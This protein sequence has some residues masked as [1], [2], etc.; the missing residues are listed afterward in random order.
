MSRR[1]PASDQASAKPDLTTTK[2]QIRAD[3]VLSR[4]QA[5]EDPE[6]EKTKQD[7]DPQ[8]SRKRAKQ[9]L[10][11]LVDLTKRVSELT[12]HKGELEL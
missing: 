10:S 12:R 4:D 11:V 1:V 2:G 5:Q 9:T 8:K 6:E 3:P 7:Q